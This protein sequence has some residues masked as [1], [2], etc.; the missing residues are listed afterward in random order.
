[1][2]RSLVSTA[3]GLTGGLIAFSFWAYDAV[4]KVTIDA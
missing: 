4:R 2:M 3:C 1:M